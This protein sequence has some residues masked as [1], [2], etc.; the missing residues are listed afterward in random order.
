MA[1][2]ITS[3]A[4][5]SVYNSGDTIE[6]T[7]TNKKE[8][9]I[10]LNLTFTYKSSSSNDV[11][12]SNITL[13]I[14]NTNIIT[15]NTSQTRVVSNNPSTGKLSLNS[16]NSYTST[17]KFSATNSTDIKST[18][19][20]VF[21]PIAS[22]YSQLYFTAKNTN[23]SLILKLE[24]NYNTKP[25]IT[26]SSNSTNLTFTGVNQTKTIT[27]VKAVNVCGNG[28][29]VF[30]NI[31]PCINVVNALLL[32][33]ATKS[34]Q[35]SYNGKN[36]CTYTWNNINVISIN[37]KGLGN[38]VTY[39]NFA[40]SETAMFNT[41]AN[42][43]STS[44]KV[45]ASALNTPTINKPTKINL[46]NK[47]FGSVLPIGSIVM[48]YANNINNLPSN[49]KVCDGSNGTPDLRDRFIIGTGTDNYTKDGNWNIV[50]AVTLEY[51]NLPH[52]TH[53]VNA[54]TTG[55]TNY[56]Y[57]LTSLDTFLHTADSDG[58]TTNKDR[59]L[60][61]STGNYSQQN[62]LVTTTTVSNN[63]VSSMGVYKYFKLIFIM[64]IK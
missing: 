1:Y 14:V 32:N 49:W 18:V 63:T 25:S 27:S 43:K 2:E 3:I 17:F 40:A 41:N 10:F 64:K 60:F 34:D 46:G 20:L 33:N 23:F 6:K 12:N 37:Y 52:H 5:D 38:K 31:N 62:N 45:D 22:G 7:S 42:I 44:I 59:Y 16:I 29:L 26:V 50:N 39:E 24:M 55:N 30:S 13:T 19:Q 21:N 36:Y 54:L 61:H 51:K 28:V 58:N 48:F 9:T 4:F 57:F 35:F 47:C 56:P 8:V 15:F 11:N 53:N